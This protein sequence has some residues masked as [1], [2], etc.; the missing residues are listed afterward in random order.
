MRNQ[1]NNVY[2]QAYRFAEITKNFIKTG[3]VA[4][5]KKCLAVAERLYV[6]GNTQT[7][8][9]ISNTYLFSVTTFLELRNCRIA[10]LLPTSLRAEYIKEINATNA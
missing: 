6:Q 4:R 3:H 10:D 5:A 9:I 1:I 7:K 2:G 8:A